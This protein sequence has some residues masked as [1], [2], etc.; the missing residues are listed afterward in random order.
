MKILGM[1]R[2]H[3][4]RKRL[5]RDQRFLLDQIWEYYFLKHDWPLAW[6][7][8]HPFKKT[9]VRNTLK[10]LGGT[11]VREFDGGH[12]GSR[13]RLT[14]HGIL[15]TSGGEKMEALLLKYL[16]Y[17]RK[18]YKTLPKNLT[19]FSEDVQKEIGLDNGQTALLGRLVIYGS[20]YSQSA[21]SG[22]I[23]ATNWSTGILQEVEEFPLDGT[24]E[25]EL[26]KLALRGFGNEQPVLIEDREP[27]KS[28]PPGFS[29]S[30]E[31][32]TAYIPNTA[33]IMMWMDKTRPELED[34]SNAIKEVCAEF[35]VHAVRADD[36]EHQ[37]KITELILE[38]I[39]NSELL[40]ADLTGE[41]P[42]VYYEVGYAHCLGKRPI[43]YRKQGSTLH[44]DLAVH[45]A[46]EYRN[47]SDLKFLLRKR[48][49]V[50]LGST[51]SGSTSTVSV[52]PP[53]D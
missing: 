9:A 3:E 11:S 22:P 14:L 1:P 23:G 7:I 35:D 47:T 5:T 41:R 19:I 37:D 40:I 38:H 45:N 29:D 17:L 32:K 15:L 2:L 13:Y 52:Q 43:L 28:A 53:E 6:E 31:V 27:F 42:N 4:L 26:E 16:D 51:R 21:S 34:V 12:Q 36:V 25:L 46:P 20:L 49:E 30:S 44:F 50:M 8:H 39:R 24:L 33:F 10:Q 18:H 48:L